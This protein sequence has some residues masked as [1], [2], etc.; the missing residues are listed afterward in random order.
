MSGEP[1]AEVIGSGRHGE[2]VELITKM[3]EYLS[4][5]AAANARRP[6]LPIA[7][8]LTRDSIERGRLSPRM[9][10]MSLTSGYAMDRLT[11]GGACLHDDVAELPENG[12]PDPAEFRVR[13]KVVE[14][15]QLRRLALI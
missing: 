4:P 15:R 6:G 14:A 7:R 2:V 12:W 1:G 11:A 3:A 5:A 8:G 10:Y 13:K 9:T